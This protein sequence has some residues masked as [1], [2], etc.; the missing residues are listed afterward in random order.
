MGSHRDFI[1]ICSGNG[2]GIGNGHK[3][4]NYVVGGGGLAF[5]R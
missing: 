2:Q 5:E 4:A 3:P 1:G